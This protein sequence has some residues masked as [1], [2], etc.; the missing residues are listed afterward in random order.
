VQSGF[1]D[2]SGAHQASVAF[3]TSDDLEEWDRRVGENATAFAEAERELAR[4]AKVATKA[5]ETYHEAATRH[6]EI[7]A[8]IVRLRLARQSAFSDA[9]RARVLLRQRAIDVYKNGVDSY[10]GAIA[11]TTFSG[12]TSAWFTG[13]GQASHGEIAVGTYLETLIGRD[14]ETVRR[15]TQAAAVLSQQEKAMEV[16]LQEERVV[17]NELGVMKTQVERALAEQEVVLAG[18]GRDGRDLEEQRRLALL[19]SAR[20]MSLTTREG[21]IFRAGTLPEGLVC[22]VAGPVSFT[23]DW[24]ALRSGGRTHKGNDLFALYGSPLVAVEDGVITKAGDD[25]GLGGLRI[26]LRGVSGTLYYYAHNSRIAVQDG[27]T[28]QQGQEIG[29]VG[30]SGNARTTPS[31][32]HF[33]THPGAG[34]AV[35]PY[36]FLL[37]VC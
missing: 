8:K 15:A 14:R 7:R 2:R 34:A 10:L 29:A 19:R 26:W 24:G 32:V 33:Q 25:G 35:N 11:S 18:L 4:L 9:L 13:A 5:T 27:E 6:T 37:E 22:P 20:R 30:N 1:S 28:V 23:N 31:H 17:E 21:E 36:G 12:G 16:V 3:P